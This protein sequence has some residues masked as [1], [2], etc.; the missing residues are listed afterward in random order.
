MPR[1]TRRQTAASK[2]AS[3]SFD[4]GASLR[5]VLAAYRS[6]R[7]KHARNLLRKL[8]S[9][10]PHN[11]DVLHVSGVVEHESGN[12]VRAVALLDQA[13]ALHPGDADCRFD[14]AEV[15]A[16][17]GRYALARNNYQH[18]LLLDP[19]QA[20]AYLGL[21]DVLLREAR[22]VEAESAFR[23]ALH[24]APQ[25]TDALWGII[26]ALNAI[27]SACAKLLRMRR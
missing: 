2:P 19:E 11:V 12:S 9:Q 3:A 20:D 13:I 27:R 14:L 8:A 1:S 23:Q 25:D 5:E 24:Y 22:C 10:A 21:G 26:G 6:G 4:K 7:I 16:A 15:Y 17:T 18:A